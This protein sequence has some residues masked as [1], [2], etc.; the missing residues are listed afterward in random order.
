MAEHFA[1]SRR[2]ALGGLAASILSSAAYSQAIAAEGDGIE[3]RDLSVP[4]D[5]S[6]TGGDQFTLRYG[7]L[8]PFNARRR[9]IFVVADGQ[10]F[11]VTPKAFAPSTRPIFIN[12]FN[13]VGIFGRADAPDVQARVGAGTAVD[14]QQAY[15]LLRADQW[16]GD[17]EA[18]RHALLGPNGLIGLY[19]RSGGAFLVHQYMA[20]HGAR[21]DRLFTQAAVNP[22]LE[23]RLGISSDHFWQEL[24][25]DDR[26]R[27]SSV[28]ASGRY[29]RIRVSRL[30]Q[31]QNF[32]VDRAGVPAARTALIDDLAEGRGERLATR[33][34]E[35]QIN[36]LDQL[37]RTPR[38]AAS[39]VRLFEFI[40]PMSVNFRRDTDRLRP[41]LEV[42]ADFAEPVMQL[43]RAG[44]IEMPAMD[45]AA[46]H[47]CTARAVIIAGR[48]D[49]TCDYR[50]QIALAAS[51]PAGELI[52]LDDDHVFHRLQQSG[53]AP[54][55][56]RAALGE[57]GPAGFAMALNKIIDLRWS[58][59]GL[60]EPAQ[61]KD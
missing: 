36:S 23:A 17:I 59:S 7:L 9:T 13:V 39:R 6:I 55:L 14:W 50:T 37:D 1:L 40:A 32:F 20:Q 8:S 51:Y 43:L 10:Q 58:E 25:P 24:G 15:R 41:N 54:A 16:I 27:L 46:L 48:W 53:Q 35:Y 18:V 21:V 34:T 56:V 29:P 3:L 11:Y 61:L 47:R 49:H 33:E 38:G 30:F 12:E 28:M 4:F 19:G 22:F 45:F 26:A 2:A 44:K 52:L 5:H 42:A 31:R 60:L 57:G